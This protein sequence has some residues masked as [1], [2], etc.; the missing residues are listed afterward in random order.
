M[1]IQYQ[2]AK[3]R[4]WTDKLARKKQAYTNAIEST[5]PFV[6]LGMMNQVQD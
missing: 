5:Q 6:E 1:Q 4:F 2:I 3:K